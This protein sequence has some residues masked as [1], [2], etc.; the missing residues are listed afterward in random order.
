MIK[1]SEILR[2]WED[3]IGLLLRG[4]SFY[5]GLIVILRPWIAVMQINE[6]DVIRGS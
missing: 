3:E 6:N 1:I 5:F 2:H 4:N